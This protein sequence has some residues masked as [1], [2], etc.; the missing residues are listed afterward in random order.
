[1]DN[2]AN[3]IIASALDELMDAVT[4]AERGDDFADPVLEYLCKY[5]ITHAHQP[6]IQ[7][8]WDDYTS[9]FHATRQD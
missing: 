3:P 1:M 7:A 6:D 8:L 9:T 2:H 4:R 5:I